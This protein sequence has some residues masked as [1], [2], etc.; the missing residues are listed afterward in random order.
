MLPGDWFAAYCT[1]TYMKT[2]LDEI[3]LDV[4]K[5]IEDTYDC[6]YTLFRTIFMQMVSANDIGHYECDL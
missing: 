6:L 5:M 1:S 4:C 3:L 2:K